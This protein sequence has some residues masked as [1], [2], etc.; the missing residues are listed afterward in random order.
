VNGITPL[1]VLFIFPNA[2]DFPRRK[3]QQAIP[4]SLLMDWHLCDINVIVA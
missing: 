3:T 4:D 2:Y 1:R